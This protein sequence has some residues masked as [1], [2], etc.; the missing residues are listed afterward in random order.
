MGSLLTVAQQYGLNG[1]Y[2]SD[3]QSL[4]NELAKG[5]RLVIALMGPGMFTSGG[6]FIVLTGVRSDGKISVADPWSRGYT[7]M[8]WFDANIFMEQRIADFLVIYK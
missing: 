8:K 3:A 5:D 6:H 7:D 2:V 1:F 4:V